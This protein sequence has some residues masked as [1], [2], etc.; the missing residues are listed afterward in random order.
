VQRSSL[1]IPHDWSG[2]LMRT[3]MHL[4]GHTAVVGAGSR[5]I[6][7]QLGIRPAGSRLII[8]VRVRPRYLA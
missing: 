4:A 7:G 1:T 6:I 8:I 3:T 2:A 5:L